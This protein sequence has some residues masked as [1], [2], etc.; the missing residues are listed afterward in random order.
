[1]TVEHVKTALITCVLT[2]YQFREIWGVELLFVL[3]GRSWAI[4]HIKLNEAV[5]AHS[6]VVSD[7]LRV[8][9]VWPQRGLMTDK[10]I[11]VTRVCGIFTV[12]WIAE[13]RRELLGERYDSTT[14][15]Q[16]RFQVDDHSTC[17]I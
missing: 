11:T 13:L 17:A 12:P 8:G 1:M 15:S 2:I 7:K 4:V 6:P 10:A 14:L 5:S 3:R 16:L 9:S